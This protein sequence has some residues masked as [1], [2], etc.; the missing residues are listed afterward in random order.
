[1]RFAVEHQVDEAPRDQG[2][3]RRP[4]VTDTRDGA[5]LLDLW[6]DDTWDYDGDVESSTDSTVTLSVRRWPGT[7]HCRVVIDADARTYALTDAVRAKELTLL[8]GRLR[9]AGLTEAAH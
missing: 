2:R 5:V 8:V 1:M 4:R 6:G 7:A 3:I 9:A